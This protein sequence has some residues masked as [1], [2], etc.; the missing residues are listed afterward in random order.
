M[1]MVGVSMAYSY[2][3]RQREGQSWSR[4][5]GHACWRALALIALAVFLSS[6][7]SRAT[8]WTFMNVLAQIGLGYPFLFLLWGRSPR[9]HA[10]TALVLLA[11][12]WLMYASFPGAGLDVTKGNP[13]AGVSAAWAQ[14]HL[15]DVGAAWHKNA[16]LGHAIDRWFLNL[17]PRAEPFAFNSGGYQTINFIPS[18]VT[19]LFGLMCGELLRSSRAAPRKALLL[20]LA[21]LGGLAAGAL[22]ELAGVPLVKRIWTPSWALYST[23]WCCLILGSLYAIMD[24]HRWRSWAF[25]LLVVGMNSIAI[26]CLGQLL[27]GWTARSLQTHLGENVFKLLGAAWAP[28]VQATLVGLVFWLVCYWM[29]RR[30][31]FLRL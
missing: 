13:Q 30:K 17:F 7:S 24:V 26:Y 16:N 21:G 4:M 31:I 8:N 14:Q 6:A 2:V 20:F 1:F 29:Y 3:R 15:T 12:V 23:G 22:L 28:F 5:F 9:F 10:L 11:G 27:R 18:L 25:P 19:M